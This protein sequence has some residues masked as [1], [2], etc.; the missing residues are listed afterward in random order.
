FEFQIIPSKANPQVMK[1]LQQRGFY[2][3][4]FHASMSGEPE[5]HDSIN[6]EDIEIRELRQEEFDKYA[7]IHCLGTGLPLDGKVHVAANKQGLFGREGWRYY[8]GLYQ[9]TPAA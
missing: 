8:I 4:G 6:K 7:E 3:S 5:Y 2:Q 1:L 9:G